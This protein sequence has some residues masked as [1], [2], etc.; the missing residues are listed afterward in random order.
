MMVKILQYIGLVFT[1][2]AVFSGVMYISK[3]DFLISFFIS[4]LF[5]V[6]TFFLINQMIKQKLEISK[7]IFSA[8]SILLWLFFLLVTIPA[9]LIMYHFLNVEINAKEDVVKISAEKMSAL[10]EMLDVY[11]VGVED[12]IQDYGT[13]LRTEYLA[14][15]NRPRTTSPLFEEPYNLN[16]EIIK[17]IKDGVKSLQ[18]CIDVKETLFDE[19][20]LIASDKRDNFIINYESVFK[21]WSRLEVNG[22]LYELDSLLSKNN[23]YLKTE[24]E[25]LCGD[26]T[27]YKFTY[28]VPTDN[29]AVNEP[30]TMWKKYKPYPLSIFILFFMGL[31]IMPYILADSGGKYNNSKS[32]RDG[33]AGKKI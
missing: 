8:T 14:Y 7:K 32:N 25:S 4:I 20:K 16:P 31:I 27:K 9:G 1:L 10:N 23:R 21:N 12:Y 29:V 19:K 2:I 3:G 17:S 33:L 6:V 26:T 18:Y 28:K 30:V 15:G 11:D 22:A 5:V 13:D 24:Y